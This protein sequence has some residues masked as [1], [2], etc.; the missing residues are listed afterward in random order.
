MWTIGFNTS[1]NK[2]ITLPSGKEIIIEAV[3]K[4]YYRK[5]EPGIMLKYST[6]LDLENVE[7]LQ[8]EVNEIWSL[9]RKE[10][11]E[12][13]LDSVVISANSPPVGKFF[14][15]VRQTRNF[16]FLKSEDGFWSAYNSRTNE[17]QAKDFQVKFGVIENRNGVTLVFE[18]RVSIPLLTRDEGF[19]YGFTILPPDNEPYNYHCQFY[20]PETA[21][22]SC[23]T[24]EVIEPITSSNNSQGFR[25]PT[26]RTQG[27]TTTPMWLDP[28]DPPGEYRIEIFIN[29]EAIHAVDFVVYEP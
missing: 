5:S 15:G 28:G 13:G 17:A 21:K 27:I 16:A 6:N 29:D 22:V 2:K 20:P 18:D 7:L 19:Y 23:E 4:I 24:G 12:S 3:G 10:A 14:I 26:R 8:N 11:D 25:L 9:F 1:K